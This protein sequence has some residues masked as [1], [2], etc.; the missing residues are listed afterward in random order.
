MN[1]NEIQITAQF[2]DPNTNQVVTETLTVQQDLQV[3]GQIN[4]IYE[5][6][7]DGGPGMRPINPPSNG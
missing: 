2:I 6:P 5:A 1:N 7:V 4:L 3:S